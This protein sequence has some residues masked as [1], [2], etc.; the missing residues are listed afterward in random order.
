MKNRHV[1]R[2]LALSLGALFVIAALG[3]AWIVHAGKD[4]ADDASASIRPEAIRADMRFLADDLL[5]GRGTG[6]R[7]HEIAAKFMASEFEAMALEPAGEKGTYFQSVPLRSVRPDEDRTTLSIVRGGQEQTFTFRQD[8]ISEG[9]P[10]EKDS[11]V[12]ASVVYVGFGVTAPE[13]KYDDYAGVEAKGKIVAYVFGAPPRFEST[14][15]AH[16]SSGDVKAANAAAHGAVGTIVLDSPAFEQLY[17][18]KD[19]VADLAF[20]SL[21]WLDAQGRPSDYFPALRARVVLSMA[22]TAKVLEGSAIS[23]EEI[24]AAAKEG[25]PRSL[26]LPATAKIRIVSKFEDMRSPNVVARLQ[27][28]DPKLQDEYVVFTAHLDHLGIGE[29]V[30]GDRIYNGALDNASGS[31]CLLEIARAYSQMKPRPRRSILFVSVTGE[32]EGLLGSDYFAHFPT[33]AKDSLVADINIDGAPLLWPIED[34]VARGAEHSK[35]DLP[36]H[37]AAARLNLEISPDPHPEQVLFIRS[38]Q[39]SFVKQGIPS[40]F[41]SAGQKSSDPKIKPEEIRRA[42]L[43]TRYHKPQDDMNQPF[44]FESG[45]RF[46]RYSFLVG[47]QIAQQNLRPA[48]N[49]GDF[50]G[51][52]F[53][54]KKD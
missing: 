7:G 41:L 14:M 2:R 30:N 1:Q 37:E 12:E 45:S 15:R 16:Y 38:D 28:S 33:V 26:A 3:Q 5:E 17:S 4:A 18:F 13:Q 47:Y 10:G 11:S 23:P 22:G 51:E 44:D 53:G 35:L 24:Y 52:H 40:L 48:W 43:A 34:L 50:F 19:Q 54:K 39:Y 49:T 46:A 25:K 29:P 36:V 27:G 42:W 32:E 9:N 20:P 21:R 31:A 6:T 8:F